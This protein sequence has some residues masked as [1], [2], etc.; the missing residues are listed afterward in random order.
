MGNRSG[1]W[2]DLAEETRK[3]WNDNAEAWHS[4]MGERGNDFHSELIL[5]AFDRLLSVQPGAAILDIGCGNGV[6]SRYLANKGARVTA[7]DA[8]TD[9]I[10]YARTYRGDID[11]KVLDATDEEAL[12]GLGERRFAAAVSSN[13]LM[14]MPRL[15]PLMRALSRL[16]LPDSPFVFSQTH[17]CFQSPGAIRMVEQQEERDGR[18]AIRHAT[19]IYHY[20]DPLHY[21]G[22][23]VANS[24]SAQNYFHRPLHVLFAQAFA[25]GF[26][27]DG[28]EEPTFAHP[29]PGDRTL[30]WSQFGQLPPLLAARLRLMQAKP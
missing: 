21:K 29:T 18:L 4:R 12:L 6:V 11:Y 5:P 25:A 3:I 8:S 23:P 17:P 1:E 22:P 24:P 13:V 15:G 9:L 30:S 19:K 14:D 2:P 7:I 26:V 16:L 28:L 27:I 20:I 10:D